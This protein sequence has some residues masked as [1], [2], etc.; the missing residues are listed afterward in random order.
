VGVQGV[1]WG[2]GG[3]VRAGGYNFLS[4]NENENYQLGTGIFVHHRIV[5]AVKRV[6]FV[7]DRVTYIVVRG[8]WC[9]RVVQKR[10]FMRN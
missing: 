5:K 10:V 7:S 2:R 4:R 1:R 9:N 3:T 8:R 6:E